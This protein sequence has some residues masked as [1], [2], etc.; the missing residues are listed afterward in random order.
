MSR[1]PSL[2]AL[3]A[4][5]A[6]A[7]TESV[8][9]AAEELNVSPSAVSHQIRNLETDLGIPL[10][11]RERRRLAI[12]EAGAAL[13]PG[14]HDGFERI[15]AA[16]A[17]LE[18]QRHAGPLTVSMVST[19][20]LRWFMA[21]L[22]RFQ[23]RHPEIELRISTTLRTVNFEREG[24]DV[25]IRSGGGDWPDLHVEHLF[26]VEIVPVCSPKLLADGPPLTR[27]ED[28]GHH[29]LL[30]ADTRPDDWPAW[31]RG[32]GLPKLDPA[33][34]LTF[35]ATHFAL[36]A[37]IQGAGIAI[38]GRP[39]IADDLALGNLIMPF[40]HME[41]IPGA[42]YLVCPEIWAERSKIVA[43]RRW[44]DEETTG[45][46]AVIAASNSN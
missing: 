46:R 34:S 25:A 4:F 5:E 9:R 3:R 12:T 45:G 32:V 24:F 41:S 21:R 28:L 10:F 43:F 29:T 8:T 36:Q 14:L 42:Y 33:R 35:E 30:Y 27:P 2:I 11:R 20:A 23:R 26:D 19:F 40:D 6:V 44:L 31:L 13:L 17:G 1:L 15:A 38:A 22:P 7:R 37:A 16:V 18:T 39:F